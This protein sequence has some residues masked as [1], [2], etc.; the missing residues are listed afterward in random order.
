[1]QGYC[2]VTVG[3]GSGCAKPLPI[4]ETVYIPSPHPHNGGSLVHSSPF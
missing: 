2:T 3:M 1:G 4:M